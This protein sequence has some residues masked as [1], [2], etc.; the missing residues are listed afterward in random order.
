MLVGLAALAAGAGAA[1]ARPAGDAGEQPGAVVASLGPG[2]RVDWTRGVLVATGAAAGDLR[3]PSSELARVKAERQARDA[4]RA[5]LRRLA[6]D[7]PLA[8]GGKLG[9]KLEGEAGERLDRAL[10]A[11]IDERI[12]H[13]SDGSVVLAAV[14]P[15]EAARAAVFGAGE[16][17]T[18]ERGPTAVLVDAGR[19]LKR[20][21]LN[22]ALAAGGEKYAG[23]TV[24]ASR[25]EAI[26]EKRLGA[27][28]MRV[29]ASGFKGGA[30][31]IGKDAGS[32]LA[33]AR[34]AGA[35][36]VVELSRRD[37][38][39]AGDRDDDEKDRKRDRGDRSKSKRRKADKESRR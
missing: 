32:Q 5:R 35:L 37:D 31:Q 13:A 26:D 11:V 23:P 17:S 38:K 8:A 16:P 24:F 15:L 12:D 29:R 1:G 39:A 27:R 9:S 20:P 28:P 19:H 25:A 18:G 34:A 7:L 36:V 2:A 30:L 22:L 10:A 6:R 14:L 4:A 33:D 3:A 21:V